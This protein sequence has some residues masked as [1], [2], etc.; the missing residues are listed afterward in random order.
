MRPLKTTLGLFLL[1]VLFFS[2]TPKQAVTENTANAAEQIQL[3]DVYEA[4]ETIK[5]II[6]P[7]FRTAN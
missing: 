5:D 4:S 2:F 3:Q 6:P 7:I 1:S